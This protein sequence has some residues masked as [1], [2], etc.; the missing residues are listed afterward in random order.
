M[1]VVFAVGKDVS[2]WVKKLVLAY[3]IVVVAGSL[4]GL[5]SEDSVAYT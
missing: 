5:A 2:P 1:N 3:A 4:F